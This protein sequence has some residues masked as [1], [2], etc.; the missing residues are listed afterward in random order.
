[1]N[2]RFR[3]LAVALSLAGVILPVT[4]GALE[5][6]PVRPVRFIVPFPAAT[7]PDVLARIAAQ[8]LTEAWA[9]PVIVEVRDGAGGAIGVNQVV[10]SAPDGYTLLFTNDIPIVIAPAV[11]K[12][13][14]DSRK[15]LLP[16]AAVA[17][18]TSV[19]V[20]NPSTGLNSVAELVALAKARP[21]TFTF[22]S[23]GDTSTS[24][25]C[26]E[27]VKQAAGIDLTQVPYKGAA[28]AIQATLTG[29]VSMYC[30]PMFQAL[31]HIKSGKLKALGVTGAKS[32]P[33]IP[34]I[35]PLAAQG[36][37]DAVVSSWYAVFASANTPSA[38][39]GKIRDSLKKVFD[40]PDVRQKLSGVGLDPIWS[41]EAVLSATIRSDLEKWAHVVQKAGIRTE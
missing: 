19:L 1:L 31:P 41:D 16:I 21:G 15:D 39:V 7:P 27:L 30:S 9:T 37:P 4:C 12:T 2:H 29:E 34:D 28:P 11:S 36:L 23:T 20:A 14:Y 6:Y 5:T 3:S 35:M 10:R 26:V 25:M 13:S 38:I 18:G 32:S 8:R 17:Q 24:R 33:L 22:A 40:D